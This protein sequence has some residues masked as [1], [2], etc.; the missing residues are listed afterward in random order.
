[1]FLCMNH[2]KLT[3]KCSTQIRGL[4]AYCVV[5]H[6]K[7]SLQT[8][9]NHFLYFDQRPMLWTNLHVVSL[10]SFYCSELS[11]LWSHQLG[12]CISGAWVQFSSDIFL[13]FLAHILTPSAYSM[14]NTLLPYQ[15][16]SEQNTATYSLP[17]QLITYGNKEQTL[18]LVHKQ[19]C[20]EGFPQGH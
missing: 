10:F 20:V 15:Q 7:V 2:T 18:Q 19:I 12:K 8:E 9:Q 4:R 17:F 11:L 13:P 16:R 3:E 5:L 14:W 1:M 6:C